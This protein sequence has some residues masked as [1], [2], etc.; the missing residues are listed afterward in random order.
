[1]GREDH[2]NE[3]DWEGWRLD[4]VVVVVLGMGIGMEAVRSFSS[5]SVGIWGRAAGGLARSERV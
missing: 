2:P 4:V 1:L 3:V 5:A